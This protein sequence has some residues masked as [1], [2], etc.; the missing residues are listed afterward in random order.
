L[1]R[2]GRADAPATD[3]ESVARAR[4]ATTQRMPEV[5]Q[6]GAG[7]AFQPVI[8]RSRQLDI[9]FFGTVPEVWTG[10]ET[11]FLVRGF[12]ELHE[13]RVGRDEPT[14]NCQPRLTRVVLRDR[15]GSTRGEETNERQA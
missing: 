10:G 4:S 5:W 7:G 8:S 1:A 14:Q 9:G 3:V 2:V 15:S 6:G 11:E 12:D 13:Q